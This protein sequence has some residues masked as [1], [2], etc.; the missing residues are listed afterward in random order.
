MLAV[1]ITALFMTLIM[2][3]HIK[4]KYTAVGTTFTF[5]KHSNTIGRKEMVIFFYLYM[6]CVL[7]ELILATNIVPMSAALYKV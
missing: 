7:L 6:A 4:S 2:V 1:N 5:G 3:M